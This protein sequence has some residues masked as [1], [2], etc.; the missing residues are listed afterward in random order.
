M[1]DEPLLD[2]VLS[3]MGSMYTTLGKFESSMHVYKRA[4]GIIQ[5][6][7][8]KASFILIIQCI[9]IAFTCGIEQ[10]QILRHWLC[11]EH[12]VCF[13]HWLCFELET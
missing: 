2:S 9:Y 6:K 7:Y 1:D 5:G 11:F 4:L 10:F 12:W 13:E 3:H 8:G